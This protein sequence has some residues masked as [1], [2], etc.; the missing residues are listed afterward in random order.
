MKFLKSS[1]TAFLCFLLTVPLRS[2]VLKVPTLE[3]KGINGRL[4]TIEWYTHQFIEN[5][6]LTYVKKDIETYDDQGRLSS[7]LTE[8]YQNNQ[9]YKT[10]YT[11][12]KKGQLE[13]IEILNPSNNLVLRITDYSYKKG[14]LI[15]T[16]QVQGTNTLV[17]NYTYDNKKRLTQVEVSQNG[18][19]SFIEYYE[20]DDQDRRTKISRKLA[21]ETETKVASTFKYE[22]KDSQLIT[23][24]NR[25]TNQG[26]FKITKVLNEANRRDISETTVKV[27]T[28]QQGIN[29]QL[30]EDDQQSNWIK[31]EVI[32]DQFGRSRLVLRRFSY[33]DGTSTGRDKL[34]FPNDY[35]GQYIRQYSNKQVAVNG[36]VYNSGV[37]F[38]LDYTDDRL[39]YI[40]DLNA[41]VLLKGYDKNSNMT[42]WMEAQVISGGGDK[43]L[44]A[45]S[46]DGIDV[47]NYG[48][49]FTKGTSRN[50]YNA[51][52]IGD[53]YTAY[54]R[55]DVNKSFLAEFPAKSAGK[56]F[57]AKLTTDHFYW[58]KLSDSTYVLSNRG[59]SV[60]LQTQVE[61]ADGNKLAMMRSGNIYY[62]YF[63]P[64]FR[65]KFDGSAIGELH[66]AEPIYDP[67]KFLSENK[68]QMDLSNFRFNKLLNGR[69]SLRSNDDQMVTSIANSSVRTPDEQLLAYFPLTKQYL[70]M[71]NYYTLDTTRE[72]KGQ[73]VTVMLDSSD[74]AYY[75]YK[76]GEKIVFYSHGKRIN[77][78]SFNTHRLD[79]DKRIMG[80]LLYDSLNNVSYGMNYDLDGQLG[81]GEMR[82]LPANNKGAYILKL[83]GDRWVVFIKG[84]KVSDYAYSKYTKDKNVVHFYKDEKG[85][86]RALHF[87]SFK[88]LQPGQFSY[89][90]DLTDADVKKYLQEFNVDATLPEKKEDN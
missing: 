49:Q 14:L 16:S 41:W 85:K 38:D 15:K 43:V 55:G 73:K 61:D 52:R 51:Y 75:L 48:R 8:N 19:Q 45:A 82:K 24:E 50:T 80:A 67:A 46:N 7:V 20:L 44:W 28:N 76:N 29:R 23:V 6:G 1:I 77:N 21:N 17:K 53:S 72:W 32:D 74:Y 89:A 2:Q 70:R 54:V 69:Y 59:K 47:F 83:K 10:V 87:S 31:G 64:G 37:A 78:R 3:S 65:D 26:E 12:S 40:N 39:C 86:T 33:S 66:Q 25:H 63:L 42:R 36:K 27:S 56:V 22:N 34:E 13:K 71:D 68:L 62:W 79:P 5:K 60:S 88:D 58:G 9:S 84:E 35:Y 57:E 90:H 4:T 18:T 30:F 11:L 81:M